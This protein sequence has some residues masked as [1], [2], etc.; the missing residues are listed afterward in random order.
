[1]WSGC[2]TAPR[3]HVPSA[4]E[5]RAANERLLAARRR[6]GPA[7]ALDEFL[8][9]VIGPDWRV[10]AERALPDSVQQMQHDA[11]TFLDTDLP[12]LLTWQFTDV[13]AQN[14]TCPVL[15]LGGTD[16]GPWFAEVHQ[17]MMTWLPHAEHVILAGADHNLALTHPADIAAA[18]TNFLTRHP[19]TF[20]S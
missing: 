9:L 11:L 4:A 7:A 17:L 14:I 12:A 8:T 16:S 13:D 3:S 18:L 19:I 10:T 5:F 20:R 1:M 15:Y 2:P 6:R